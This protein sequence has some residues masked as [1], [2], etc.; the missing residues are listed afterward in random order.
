VNSLIRL[1][2]LVS[3]LLSLFSIPSKSQTVANFDTPACSG[4]GV[5]IYQGINFSLSPWDCGNSKLTGDSTETISWYQK[6]TTGKF[7]FVS[8]AI[9]V[10]LRAGSSS[11]SGLLTVTSDA[12]ETFS[13]QLTG[14]TVSGPFQTNFTK[15]SSVITVSFP[16]GWTIQLDDITYQ[17]AIASPPSAATSVTVSCSP[18]SLT[19]LG[20][21]S[22][23]AATVLGTGSFSTA[24]SWS[25][26]NGTIS[27]S[28]IL[29]PSGS[30]SS[31]KVT[32]A[33]VQTPSVVG[34][35]TVGLVLA[36]LPPACSDVKV[37][38]DGSNFAPGATVSFGTQSLTVTGNTVSQ[39]VG[40]L[41]CSAITIT[42]P[43]NGV[44]Q[45]A[46]LSWNAPA[47]V[48]GVT[49][50]SYNVYRGAVSGGPYAVLSAVSSGESYSDN[51]VV[52]GQTY[53]Y[54][55][56]SVG[57]NGDESLFSNEVKTTISLQ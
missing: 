9:L 2:I 35:A 1:F 26:S 38:I 50:A 12:G 32:A 5:G 42:N 54:V 49:V 24:V 19:A 37:T 20:Q 31:V 17:S 57:T 34:T 55:I 22:Q 41:P 43:V 53:Y 33:S 25:T 45:V 48:T 28:G 18:G 4:N 8:P 51:S 3:L 44:Q 11:G 39:L 23:C 52:S 30:T 16:G 40:T 21:T 46:V 27:S 14:G 13:T 56:T 29:T 36:A 6:I 10:S 15:T 47:P 7:Q